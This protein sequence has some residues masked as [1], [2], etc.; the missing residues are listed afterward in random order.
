MNRIS[1]RD[2]CLV[3]FLTFLLFGFFIFHL[4]H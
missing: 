3:K 1:I 4:M 2:K